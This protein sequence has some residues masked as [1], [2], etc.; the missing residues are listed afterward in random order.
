MNNALKK[1]RAFQEKLAYLRWINLG[2]ESAQEDVLLEQMDDV[3]WELS[4]DE[5]DL[6]SSEP[7][8]QELIVPNDGII[9]KVVDNDINNSPGPVRTS[10]V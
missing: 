10:N 3:W 6:L 5:K 8:S 9:S 2:C 1:Y 4:P 7:V